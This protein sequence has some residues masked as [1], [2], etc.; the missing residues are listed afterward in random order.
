[1]IY[2]LLYAN[3]QEWLEL[4]DS[5]KDW[6]VCERVYT[7]VCTH[8]Q[9]SIPSFRR[10]G[11]RSCPGGTEKHWRPEFSQVH[12]NIM[13]KSPNGAGWILA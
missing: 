3:P 13:L 12:L 8:T 11:A 9:I 6:K 10:D 7:C 4:E 2:Q 1:M 5:Y